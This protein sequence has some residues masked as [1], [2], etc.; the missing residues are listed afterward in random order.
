MD[1]DDLTS[2]AHAIQCDFVGIDGFDDPADKEKAA[3]Q[4]EDASGQGAWAVHHLLS[5]EP[6]I[7]DHR[8]KHY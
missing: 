2:R 3:D 8:I 4:D 7:P 5:P 1:A 6:E